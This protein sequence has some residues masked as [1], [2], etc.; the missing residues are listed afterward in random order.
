MPSPERDDRGLNQRLISE[1]TAENQWMYSGDYQE[2]KPR[3]L[4]LHSASQ[5]V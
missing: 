3:D 1:N 4:T 2:V 5:V